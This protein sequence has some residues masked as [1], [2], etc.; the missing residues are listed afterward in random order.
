MIKVLVLGML[1]FA[2]SL[3]GSQIAWATDYQSGMQQAK[4]QNKPVL[5]VLSRHTC[6]YC[7]MLDNTTFKDEKVI[8]TLNKNFISII[9]Y[10]D[11]HDY[12]PEELLTSATPALWFLLPNG[13]AMYQPL[14]GA[15]DAENLLKAL[16]VVKEDFDTTSKKA[17]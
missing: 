5:F 14:L 10:S 3:F 6:K 2:S 13:E 1:L 4:M 15:M 8:S 16:V 7:V 12:T 9:S 17:K 11:E